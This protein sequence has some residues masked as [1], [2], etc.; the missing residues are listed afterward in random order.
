M[1]FGF[2]KF[3]GRKV[4]AV[5]WGD[6][7]IIP[8]VK[9]MNIIIKVEVEVRNVVLSL[10]REGS[11]EGGVIIGIREDNSFGNKGVKL[12]VGYTAKRENG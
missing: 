2:I 9:R 6:A 1:E 4:V 8:F 7:I 11:R 12:I 3:P 5:D 10:G